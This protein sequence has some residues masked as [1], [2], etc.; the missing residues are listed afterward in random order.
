MATKRNNQKGRALAERVVTLIERTTQDDVP[1]RLGFA[2]VASLPERVRAALA[3]A[4]AQHITDARDPDLPSK[5]EGP[6]V[7]EVCEWL[8]IHDALAETEG[9]EVTS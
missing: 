3:K 5:L 4:L 8:S 9:K 6:A 7:A 2:V 1:A